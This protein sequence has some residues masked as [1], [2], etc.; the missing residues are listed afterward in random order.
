M[1]EYVFQSHDVS[2]NFQI[3]KNIL[4]VCN[5]GRIFAFFGNLGA[6]KTTLI[7]SLCEVLGVEE[8]VTSPTFTLVN[9]YESLTSLVYH[10][11][12]Y[13]IRHEHEAYDIGAEDYFYSGSYVFI[14][15]PEKIP[16]LL[17]EDAIQVHMKVEENNCRAIKLIC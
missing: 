5:N 15:W 11:D 3:A 14:E 16:S 9:E 12:F 10:F 2:D 17:P 6:G 8:P 13:R 7:K 4:E 1:P